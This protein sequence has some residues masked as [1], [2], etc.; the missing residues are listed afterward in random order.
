MMA[1]SANAAVVLTF[2]ENGNTTGL[3]GE[4][5][6]SSAVDS[7]PAT[8][9]SHTVP[10]GGGSSTLEYLTP[11]ND[12]FGGQAGAYPQYGWVA[13]YAYGSPNSDY[14]TTTGLLDLIHFSSD[15]V[16]TY[17]EMFFYSTEGSGNLA[18]HMPGSSV[19]ASVLAYTY[20]TSITEGA[21]G[22]SFYTPAN[23]Y[24][25][26][27]TVGTGGTQYEYEFESAVVPIPEPGF[28]GGCASTMM[29]LWSLR[30]SM[31]RNWCKARMV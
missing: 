11:L 16:S 25:A 12:A 30:R 10:T 8:V 27:Y 9:N 23:S 1:C 7:L 20:T 19:I 2:D 21:T 29:L 31:L 26:G 5:Y 28:Y 17:D 14:G 6:N 4:K 24:S 13:I 22:N 18:D 15:T 3:T